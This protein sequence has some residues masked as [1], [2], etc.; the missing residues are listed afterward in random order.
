MVSQTVSLIVNV[1]FSIPHRFLVIIWT[2]IL[3]CLVQR[4]RS[5]TQFFIRSIFTQVLIL[6]V[7]TVVSSDL[8]RHRELRIVLE[9]L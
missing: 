1:F 8:A 5:L 2:Q 6:Q 4:W 3:D 9:A 7:A